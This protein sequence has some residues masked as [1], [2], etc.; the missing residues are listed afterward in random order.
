MHDQNYFEKAD[1]RNQTLTQSMLFGETDLRTL[2][3]QK[4]DIQSYTQLQ[5]ESWVKYDAGL[6]RQNKLR[7]EGELLQQEEL[8]QIE[9]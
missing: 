8:I 1:D 5:N 2:Q 6:A 7:R 9:I 4:L 3:E